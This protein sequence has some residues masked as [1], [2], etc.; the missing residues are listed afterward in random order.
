MRETSHAPSSNLTENNNKIWIARIQN[1]SPIDL[2][3]YETTWTV[4]TNFTDK[5]IELLLDTG[6]QITLINENLLKN[7]IILVDRPIELTGFDNSCI[8]TTTKGMYEGI[9][10]TDDMK[11]WPVEIHAVDSTRSGPY[12]GYLGYDF[13]ILYKANIDLKNGKLQLNQ[14]RKQENI[15]DMTVNPDQIDITR[16]QQNNYRTDSDASTD[17]EESADCRWISSTAKIRTSNK[18]QT[19]SFTSDNKIPISHSERIDT[20]PRTRPSSREAH[21]TLSDLSACS[22]SAP[23]DTESN[24]RSLNIFQSD[25][26]TPCKDKISMHEMDET[27]SNNDI[28]QF[29]H[30]LKSKAFSDTDDQITRLQKIENHGLNLNSDAKAFI[31]NFGTKKLHVQNI[32]NQ[33]IEKF[34]VHA[35]A[36]QSRTKTIL[37]ALNLN[38]LNEIEKQAV[39]KIVEEFK[40][41]FFIEGDALAK[42]DLAI[43]EIHL[44]PGTGIIN[45]KQFRLPQTTHAAIKN[46]TQDMYNLK[47]IRDSKSPFNAPTFMVSKKDSWGGNIDLRQVHDYRDLNKHTIVQDYPIPRVQELIDNFSQCKFITIIDI[48]SAF[49]QIEMHEPHKQFTAFTLACRKFEFNRMPFGLRGAPITMQ[50]AITRALADLL[51]SGVSAYMDD[52]S[53][54]TRTFDEHVKL[55]NEVFSRLKKHNLQANIKK[56]KFFAPSVE[57]LGFVIENG[58]VKPNPNKTKAIR[59][60]PSPK[61]RK[62]LQTFLGMI[63]YYKIFIKSFAHIARPLH[64]LTSPNIVYEW[65]ETTNKAFESLKLTLADDV[66]LK[67][68]DFTKKF[69]LATDASDVAIGAVLSQPDDHAKAERPIHFYSRVLDIHERNYKVHERELL[70]LTNAIAEFENYLKGRKF[71]VLTDSQCLVFL[72]TNTNKNK[73]LVRQAITI[74]DANFDIKYQPGKLNVVADALSRI[75]IEDPEKWD[76]IPIDEFIKRHVPQ[77][78]HI[79]ALTRSKANAFD[80]SNVQTK[81]KPFIVYNNGTATED[82]DYNHIFS[83]ITISNKTLIRRFVKDEEFEKTS[84]FISISP[85]HSF[86]TINSLPAKQNELKSIIS[87]I[88]KKVVNENIPNIAINTDLMAKYLFNFK[89]LLNQTFAQIKTSI[90]LHVNQIIELTDPL[91]INELLKMHHHLRLGG[92]AGIDRM[93]ATMKKNYTWPNMTQDIKNYVANCNICERAKVTRYTRTPMMITSTAETPFEH[94]YIDYV[95]PISPPSQEGYK[96]IFVATCELTK[97]SIAIPTFDQTSLTTAEVYI[98]HV[99]LQYGFPAVVTSDRGTDFM[100]ELFKQVNKMLKIKQISTT[101][102]NPKANIVERRNRSTSE[103]LRCYT[104]LRPDTWAELLPYCTI[105]GAAT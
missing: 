45:V 50:A 26:L 96:N 7:D 36:N 34:K 97:F 17:D 49:H 52:V 31:R 94:M 72:F 14:P 64:T 86:I 24:A 59:S 13:L 22:A 91:E 10:I 102:Y 19:F 38:R 82:S 5:P 37:S 20:F 104:E 54:Y 4:N 100:S 62:Q 90:S 95:G 32:T 25:T 81:S 74:L 73:R 39:Y 98:K 63:N 8:A 80:D 1:K 65:D 27:P 87:S 3:R 46:S 18:N 58:T 60:Y 85:R 71:T 16:S 35:I 83:V 70:A 99:I 56:C 79:R 101:P 29:L 61:T 48:K 40:N 55:L 6:A 78:K 69:T 76:E 21:H 30:D 28:K 53:I 15:S 41:Q 75:E 12:D 23:N 68:V 43:H 9:F 93:L 89:F 84:K 47:I 33:H 103:Y 44:K 2:K 67:I 42:T 105:G 11:K 51:D 57:Y 77:T 88:Y 66:T 92:H